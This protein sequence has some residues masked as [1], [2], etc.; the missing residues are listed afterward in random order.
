MLPAAADVT[1][2][3]QNL[4]HEQDPRDVFEIAESK[5]ALD[6]LWLINIHHDKEVYECLVKWHQDDLIAFLN[7]FLHGLEALHI[8]VQ[9]LKFVTHVLVENP[10]HHEH[11]CVSDSTMHLI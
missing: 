6:A 11:A 3:F 1:C 7:M 10:D 9:A 8:D 2:P 5:S 4:L